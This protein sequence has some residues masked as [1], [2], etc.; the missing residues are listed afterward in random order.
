MEEDF[1]TIR[2]C[3]RIKREM[4]RICVACDV[5]TDLSDNYGYNSSPKKV[6]MLNAPVAER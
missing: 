5:L 2:H 1:F 6:I 4:K 3:G